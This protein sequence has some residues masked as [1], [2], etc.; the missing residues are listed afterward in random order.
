MTLAADLFDP[1]VVATAGGMAGS[2]AWIGGMSFS[3]LIGALADTIG[4]NPLFAALARTV[5]S[6]SKPSGWP[7]QS[8]ITPPAW[9]TT[10]TTGI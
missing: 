4:Y 7:A 10:S 8:L 6:D 2:A 1:R 9:R 5:P 3:L